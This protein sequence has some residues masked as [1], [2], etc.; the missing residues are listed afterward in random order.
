V[1]RLF[2]DGVIELQR[3]LLIYTSKGSNPIAYW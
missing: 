1:M 3:L 2:I